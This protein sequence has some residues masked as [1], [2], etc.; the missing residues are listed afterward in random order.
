MMRS[1]QKVYWRWLLIE[2]W[3]CAEYK[4]ELSREPGHRVSTNQAEVLR[5]AWSRAEREREPL[6]SKQKHIHNLNVSGI[7]LT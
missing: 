7:F 4:P 5:S 3:G 1:L 2:R 6:N